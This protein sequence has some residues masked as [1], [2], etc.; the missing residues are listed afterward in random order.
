M[1][2]VIWGKIIDRVAGHNRKQLKHLGVLPWEG[3][4]TKPRDSPKV[5][6]GDVMEKARVIPKK[7]LSSPIQPVPS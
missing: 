3:H 4:S 1:C 7:Q 5:T 6:L 2:G